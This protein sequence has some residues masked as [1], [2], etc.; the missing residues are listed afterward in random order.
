MGTSNQFE[1]ANWYFFRGVWGGGEERN[2][3][4]GFVGDIEC[5]R[6]GKED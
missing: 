5:E 1:K 2:Q 3:E 4:R 6:S